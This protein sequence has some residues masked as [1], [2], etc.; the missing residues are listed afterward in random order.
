MYA[1]IGE[2]EDIGKRIYIGFVELNIFNYYCSV[3]TFDLFIIFIAKES[4]LYGPLL[5][6]VTR[7]PSG[8]A[9]VVAYG[10]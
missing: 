2:I 6:P 7:F 8:S 5:I 3:I 1:N 10:Q 9:I 4:M